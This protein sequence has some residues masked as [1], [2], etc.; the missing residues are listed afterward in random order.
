[1]KTSDILK[2]TMDQMLD[3]RSLARAK[4]EQHD[5]SI[6]RAERVKADRDLEVSVLEQKCTAAQDRQA[7]ALVNQITAGKAAL[8]DVADDSLAGELAVARERVS[9][10]TKALALLIEARKPLETNAK[11]AEAAIENLIRAEHSSRLQNLLNDLH[12][13]REEYNEKCVMI[14]SMGNL[15]AANFTLPM[16]AGMAVGPQ[17]VGGLTFVSPMANPQ[18]AN[19]RAQWETYFG[20]LRSGK[21]I[22]PPRTDREEA[23]GGKLE[24]IIEGSVAE[25]LS[26]LQRA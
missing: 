4:L 20:V 8:R 22:D 24:R 3:K 9:I 13:I 25:A 11:A 21:R 7:Q 19:L 16:H 14:L 18:Y 10:A 1:V 23:L 5:T 12:S 2:E 26:R 15:Q 17:T 6:E